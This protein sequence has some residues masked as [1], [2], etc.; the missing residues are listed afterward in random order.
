[1]SIFNQDENITDGNLTLFA[2][3]GVVSAASLPTSGEEQINL[4][5]FAASG[6]GNSTNPAQ[7]NS[8]KGRYS[9]PGIKAVIITN[10]TSN[11]TTVYYQYDYHEYEV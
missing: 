1:M 8:V 10:L 9:K 6:V 2:D 4:P 7:T 11:P 5:I 3:H